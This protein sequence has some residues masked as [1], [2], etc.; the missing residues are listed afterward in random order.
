VIEVIK[1]VPTYIY[2]NLD[3]Q[4]PPDEY[5]TD[6][7][8]QAEEKFGVPYEKII[9]PS[10][11]KRS[12]NHTKALLFLCRKAKIDFPDTTSKWLMN[13]LNISRHCTIYVYWYCC[14]TDCGIERLPTKYYRSKK[15]QSGYFERLKKVA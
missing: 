8:S 5:W 10:R 4:N 3:K 15:F 1:K 12:T 14:K 7:L 6:L 2:Q 13:R 11:Y 9:K